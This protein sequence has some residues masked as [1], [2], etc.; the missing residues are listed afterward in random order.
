MFTLIVL[1]AI[2]AWKFEWAFRWFV[3]APFVGS[4]LG[5]F[6]W[7]IASLT[8][9]TLLDTQTLGVLIIVCTAA[10]GITTHPE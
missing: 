4:G 8:T 5:L 3:L 9:D 10:V 6:V 2:M 7:G 1:A